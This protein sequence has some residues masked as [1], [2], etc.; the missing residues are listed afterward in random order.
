MKKLI[1]VLA[2]T[3]ALT[4]SYNTLQST[5]ETVSQ[6]KKEIFNAPAPAVTPM[7]TASTPAEELYSKMDFAGKEKMKPKVLE[8]ALT[9]F[10]NLKSAGKLPETSKLLT[11]C[12]FTL[13]SNQKRMWVIN[14]ETGEILFNNLVAHGK[15]TGEEFAQNFSNTENSYQSSL[16][17]YITDATYEGENGYS[18]RLVGMD[19]GY[20]DAAEK[21]A[22]VMHGADYVSESFAKEHQRIGRSWGCPSVARELAV[23]II[24]TIKGRNVLFIYYPDAKYL[25]DSKWLNA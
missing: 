2:A 5:P 19:S 1:A 12:D 17:F 3:F 25:K 10:N 11:V 18:L 21:R 7:A 16:G 24:N 20:N 23:P 22:I 14:V 8:K 15:N 9:G 13:S 4:T 6:I